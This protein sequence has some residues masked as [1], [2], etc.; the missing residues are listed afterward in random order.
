MDDSWIPSVCYMC[1]NTCRI[2]VRRSGGVITSI[3]GLPG[4]PYNGSRLC[5]KG[6][7]GLMSYYNP[8]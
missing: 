8:R 2:R 6:R 3:E 5:A 1:Y 7:A 4:N